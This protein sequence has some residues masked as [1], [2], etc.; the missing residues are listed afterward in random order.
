MKIHQRDLRFKIVDLRLSGTQVN[1]RT[2]NSEAL[3]IIHYS[4][5]IIHYSLFII[6]PAPP[7]PYPTFLLCRIPLL[8]LLPC[9]LSLQ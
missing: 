5:F 9:R 8:F 4:L 6:L 1:E 2:F 7:H 3:F